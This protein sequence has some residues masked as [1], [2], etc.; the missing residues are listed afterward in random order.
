M[1]LYDL[2]HD[3]NKVHWIIKLETLFPQIRTSFQK[4][5]TLT[6]P[7]TN[8]SFFITVNSSFIGIGCFLFQIKVYY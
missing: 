8:H 3:C 4:K 7:N 6:P 2:L 1:P 5:G